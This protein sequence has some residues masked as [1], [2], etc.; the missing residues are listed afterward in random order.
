M[1]TWGY[2]RFL[3]ILIQCPDII[4]NCSK[5]TEDSW[6]IKNH[7]CTQETYRGPAERA[8]SFTSVRECDAVPSLWAHEV[9]TW[10]KMNGD[11]HVQIRLLSGIAWCKWDKSPIQMFKVERGLI[12]KCEHGEG[13]SP[14]LYLCL[15]EGVDEEESNSGSW[16]VK[17]PNH[18]ERL[19]MKPI[20]PSSDCPSLKGDHDRQGWG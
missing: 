13:S 7:P 17:A 19:Q 9:E 3:L 1:L 8:F 14:A 11:I 2:Q 20:V 5:H 15:G 16:K 10:F 4:I 6:P 18:V 12:W